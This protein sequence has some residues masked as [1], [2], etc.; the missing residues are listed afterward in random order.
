M[1][2]DARV[3]TQAILTA[4]NDEGRDI[5]QEEKDAQTAEREKAEKVPETMTAV[6]PLW[7]AYRKGLV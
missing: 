3:K 7:I 5:V 1:L 2:K 4:W 6:F